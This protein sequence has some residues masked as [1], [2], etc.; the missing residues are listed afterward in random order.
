[1]YQYSYPQL[2]AHVRKV[3]AL[4]EKSFYNSCLLAYPHVCTHCYVYLSGCGVNFY[5][6]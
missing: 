5:D 2:Y 3:D 6:E 1:M 4:H